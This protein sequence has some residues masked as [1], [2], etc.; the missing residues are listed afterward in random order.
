MS[1]TLRD[2]VDDMSVEEYEAMK[3]QDR[4]D[5]MRG[6]LNHISTNLDRI[7]H[8]RDLYKKDRD[9]WKSDAEAL[10]KALHHCYYEGFPEPGVLNLIAAHKR[11]TEGK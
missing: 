11:L 9:L 7:I 2:P 8:D 5:A 6:A 10:A 3:E 4:L 1:E